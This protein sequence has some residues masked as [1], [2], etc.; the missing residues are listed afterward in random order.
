MNT[1]RPAPGD[2]SPRHTKTRVAIL[3]A[4]IS[5]AIGLGCLGALA[6]LVDLPVAA[7]SKSNQALI[8]RELLRA[9]NFSE[10]SAHGL[11]VAILL[12]MT[13][14]LDPTLKMP[15]LRWP[16]V[17]WPSYQPL[18]SQQD[19]ARM[20]CATYAGGLL[21]NGLKL[22]IVRVRPS[23]ADLTAATQAI[24]TFGSSLLLAGRTSHTDLQSFPSGHSAVAAGFAAAL[25]WKYP[26]GRLVFLGLALCAM[27]Q[28]VA[29]MAH[30]P[31]DVAC[32][33]AVGLCGAALFLSFSSPHEKSVSK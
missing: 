1:S 4:L 32:G 13:L 2:R 28:R 5:S 33:A 7:W 6:L 20:A 19:F 16:A 22:L 24:D 17:C 9:L 18:G 31:S 3:P 30:Y 8:P 12:L 21:V 26:R 25:A 23:A 10:V 29:T 15:S 14:V 27:T 11:G